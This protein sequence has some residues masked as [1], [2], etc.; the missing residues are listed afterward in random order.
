MWRKKPAALT[1]QNNTIQVMD[2]EMIKTL[3][4]KSWHYILDESLWGLASTSCTT[5]CGKASAWTYQLPQEQHGSAYLMIK[6]KAIVHG[7]PHEIFDMFENSSRSK[8][9][10]KYSVGRTDVDK[11]GIDGL[12]KVV[13]S[14]TKPPGTK[15]PH[16]FCT[17]IHGNKFLN[18]THLIFST[19]VDHRNVPPSPEYYRSEILLGA[20]LMTPV[21][22][23]KTELTT[24]NH[25][26]TCGVPAFLCNKVSPSASLSFLKELDSL[27]AKT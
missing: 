24:I 8:E 27:F 6:T 10:N 21:G 19:A 13:W 16:D 14:R 1:A 2:N 12:T 7:T 25:V 22:D 17:L 5:S 20:T 4:S 18:G 26:K 11:V 23:D 15:K 9:Y 3:V